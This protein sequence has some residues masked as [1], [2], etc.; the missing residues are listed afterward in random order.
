M[1]TIEPSVKE[2]SAYA[3]FVYAV[4]SEI[5]RDYYLRRFRIFFNYLD[6]TIG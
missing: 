1:K 5:T 3:L 2:S 6:F 4:R